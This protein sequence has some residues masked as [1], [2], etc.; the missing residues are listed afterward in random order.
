MDLAAIDRQSKAFFSGGEF[1]WCRSEAE[2]WAGLESRLTATPHARLLTLKFSTARWAAAA[3]IIVILSLTGFARFYTTS[4]NSPA[5]QHLQTTLPDSSHISLNA[6]SSVRFHPYW[7]RI[8]REVNLEGEAFFEVSKGRK[9]TVESTHGTTRVLGTSF[10]IYA[11]ADVYNVTC[12]TG[13]VWVKSPV[14]YEAVIK[15]N[16]KAIVSKNGKIDVLTNIETYPEISWRKNIFL[17][18]STPAPR[19]FRE[20]ER[21]YGVKIDLRA[22]DESLYTGNFSKKQNV[23]EILSY[24]CPA[25]GLKFKQ[26]SSGEFVISRENE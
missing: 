11:R 19:V 18:T 26:T 2:V 3:S 10:N 20:I 12:V 24:V 6:E 17:F 14:G 5:G 1:V 9:F 21:Q 7:W 22:N 23:E 13:T 15:P 25:L 8:S 4:V 16:S